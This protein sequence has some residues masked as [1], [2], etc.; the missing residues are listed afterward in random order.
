MCQSVP[1]PLAVPSNGWPRFVVIFV[2]ICQPIKMK[3]IEKHV[4]VEDMDR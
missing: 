4:V 1:P 3:Y 2:R